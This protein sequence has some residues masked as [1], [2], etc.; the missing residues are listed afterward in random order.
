VKEP[1]SRRA[2]EKHGKRVGFCSAIHPSIVRR[3]KEEK[4]PTN[5]YTRRKNAGEKKW[6]KALS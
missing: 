2:E 4:A 6:K 5:C 1:R 3:E